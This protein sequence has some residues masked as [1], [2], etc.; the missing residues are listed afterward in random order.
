[1]VMVTIVTQLS[2]PTRICCGFHRLEPLPRGDWVAVRA[3]PPPVRAKM[4][5]LGA[6]T[7][8]PPSATPA[9]SC[10]IPSPRTPQFWHLHLANS[11]LPSWPHP[12]AFFHSGNTHR[13]STNTG[14]GLGLWGP[15]Q[16]GPCTHGA[17]RS[18]WRDPSTREHLSKW[19]RVHSG[20]AVVRTRGVTGWTVLRLWGGA[21]ASCIQRVTSGPRDPEPCGH[22][23]LHGLVPTAHYNVTAC[24]HPKR[25]PP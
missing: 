17:A 21:Q 20:R 24:S 19:T 16:T 1:M 5:C 11:Y 8:V 15:R 3:L 14:H 13:V 7:P 6:T 25:L 23:H 12:D 22:P 2:M 18:Q 10:P 4:T 9:T